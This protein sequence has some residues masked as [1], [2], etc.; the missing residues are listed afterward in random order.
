[1]TR[2]EAIT[3][4]HWLKRELIKGTDM[5]EPID[6]AIE[7]L[8]A[9]DEAESSAKICDICQFRGL[10]GNAE[11]CYSAPQT[12]PSDLIS[13]KE[14]G[15]LTSIREQIDKHPYIDRTDTDLISRAD[16][17]ERIEFW[18]SK[19]MKGIMPYEL[20]ALINSIPSVSAE[21]VVRCKDCEYRNESK[22]CSIFMTYA[23]DDSFCSWAKMKGGAE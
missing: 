17:M 15:S 6:M 21:R 23:D 7:A 5:N 1:M 2:E 12:E 11:C 3:R 9:I 22:A 18:V 10:K 13:R 8:S 14:N 19:Q 16:V 20:E 4:L